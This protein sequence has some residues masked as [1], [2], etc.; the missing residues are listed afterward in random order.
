LIAANGIGTVSIHMTIVEHWVFAF[1]DVNTFTVDFG[2]TV[3]TDTDWFTIFHD[4]VCIVTAI[5]VGACWIAFVNSITME[6][7][8]ALAVEAAYGVDA[9]CI[10][11][12]VVQ[13]FSTFVN[14]L[15]CLTIGLKT[16][17]SCTF[18]DV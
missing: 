11:V 15:A 14:V 3:G 12:A 5:N 18:A 17:T 2:E 6:T 9:I 4:A 10:D 1:V 8:F 16:G 7:S 13:I